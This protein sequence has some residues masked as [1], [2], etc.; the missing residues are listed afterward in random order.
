MPR[1]QGRDERLASLFVQPRNTVTGEHSRN[2]VP[3]HASSGCS[4]PHDTKQHIFAVTAL[5]VT[6][7]LLLQ[8]QSGVFEPAQTVNT[9]TRTPEQLVKDQRAPANLDRGN[10]QCT[11][12]QCHP[13][14]S[15][16]KCH[17]GQKPHRAFQR[18]A[19]GPVCVVRHP[20]TIADNPDHAKELPPAGS[21]ESHQQCRL[22]AVVD[23]SP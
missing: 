5:A 2:Y 18:H 12:R 17:A 1:F 20:V 23:K 11:R 14:F 3:Q 10:T 16:T 4:H 21:S 13:F 22:T 6:N 7:N 8:N 15:S 19:E 9:S